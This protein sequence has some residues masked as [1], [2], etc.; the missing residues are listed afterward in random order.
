MPEGYRTCLV[1]RLFEIDSG[2]EGYS[3]WTPGDPAR[4]GCQAGLWEL[5][6]SDDAQ[7]FRKKMLTAA[8]CKDF[9]RHDAEPAKRSKFIQEKT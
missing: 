6:R 1:C 9:V 2:T 8:C 4:V 3:E 7:D 5:E